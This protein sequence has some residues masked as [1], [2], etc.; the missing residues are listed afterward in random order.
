MDEMGCVDPLPQPSGCLP[1]PDERSLRGAGAILENR[2]KAGIVLL[3]LICSLLGRRVPSRGG[4]LIFPAGS[5]DKA[6]S[7]LTAPET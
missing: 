5:G 4:Q 6:V 7:D 1:L 2:P 3:P